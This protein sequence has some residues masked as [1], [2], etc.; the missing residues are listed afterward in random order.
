M[1]TWLLS[2]S[3]SS[4]HKCWEHDDREGEVPALCPQAQGLSSTWLTQLQCCHLPD[5]PFPSEISPR[6]LD[7]SD[8]D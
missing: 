2:A 7:R 1:L 4:N 5:T 6:P 8:I 3:K